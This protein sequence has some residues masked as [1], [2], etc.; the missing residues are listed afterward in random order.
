MTRKFQLPGG[1]TLAAAGLAGL[2][3]AGG[4]VAA[5]PKDDEGGDRQT[6]WSLEE[7]LEH[8]PAIVYEAKQSGGRLGRNLPSGP[9]PADSLDPDGPW[10]ARSVWVGGE[11]GVYDLQR[12]LDDGYDIHVKTH[13]FYPTAPAAASI[14][15][16]RGSVRLDLSVRK[17]P[18][19]K[20]PPLGVEWACYLSDDALDVHIRLKRSERPAVNVRYRIT[21][22]R[23]Y[24]A[25]IEYR[26]AQRRAIEP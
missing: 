2:A 8:V 4:A 9:P 1:L 12:L 26:R 10:E 22:R 19:R 18:G 13:K 21:D 24:C 14:P 5:Q 7:A 25:L 16:L 15:G 17:R 3:L 20:T 23:G 11:A 6:P